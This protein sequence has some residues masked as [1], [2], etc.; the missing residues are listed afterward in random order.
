MSG[1]S[2]K[3]GFQPQPDRRDAEPLPVDAHGR[4]VI[5]ATFAVLLALLV[6]WVA[7]DFLAPLAWAAV[8]A[9]TVWPAYVRFAAFLPGRTAGLLAPLAFT[10]LVGIILLVPVVLLV[11][12][13]AQGGD[14]FGR[15]VTE[16]RENGIP[17]PG[18]IL[19]TPGP[20]QLRSFAGW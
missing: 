19:Q 11:Q 4:T 18:W 1:P 20:D 16:L 7:W 17:V 9:I 2:R 8:I 5:R 13:I 10:L 12:H 6:L 3:R 14:A 15:W